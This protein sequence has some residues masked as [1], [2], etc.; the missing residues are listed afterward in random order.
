MEKS[1]RLVSQSSNASGREYRYEVP[2]AGGGTTQ[3]TVQQQTMDSSHP[4][5]PHWEAGKV[6]VDPATGE[7]RMNDYDRPKIANPKGKAN[8]KPKGGGC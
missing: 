1:S 6:K 4:G 8:Y 5:E 2:K 3:A 7:T